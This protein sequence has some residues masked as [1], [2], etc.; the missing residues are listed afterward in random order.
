MTIALT[1]PMKINSEKKHSVRYD[2]ID[3]DAAV[4]SVYVMRTSIPTP[5]P[6]TI[7]I[8]VEYPNA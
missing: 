6:Q 8:K 1:I 4:I 7:I 2:A 3:K 5:I